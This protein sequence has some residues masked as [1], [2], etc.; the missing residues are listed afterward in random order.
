MKIKII[1][2]LILLLFPFPAYSS[3]IMHWDFDD[4]TATDK[5][6]STNGT[7]A[8]PTYLAGGGVNGSGAFSFDG[9]NDYIAPTQYN[10]IGFGNW[11]I[12]FWIKTTDTAVYNGYAG[13]PQVSVIGNI[14]GAIGFAVGVDGGK[15]AFYHYYSGWRE[16]KGTSN[17]ADGEGHY[18]SYVH[19]STGTLDIYV[20]GQAEIVGANAFDAQY[21]YILRDIG[22]SYDPKYANMVLDDLRVYNEALTSTTIGSTF[23]PVSIPEPTVFVLFSISVLMIF[24]RRK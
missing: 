19:H 21:I 3:L 11:T 24:C 22:R 12:S 14:T 1:V 16:V 17:V 2:C 9:A 23:S 10:N 15:A 7:L 20:D 18:I 13:T 4:G 6:G 5:A 8:G